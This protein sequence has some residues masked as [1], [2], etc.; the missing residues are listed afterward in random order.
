MIVSPV[1]TPSGSS[2]RGFTFGTPG[3]GVV[4]VTVPLLVKVPL[5]ISTVP[6]LIIVPVV[7]TTIFPASLPKSTPG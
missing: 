7:D 3:I 6:R 2:T 4:L 5:L 1:I